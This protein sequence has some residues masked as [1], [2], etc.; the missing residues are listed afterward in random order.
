[1]SS[2]IFPN[3]PFPTGTSVSAYD[4]QGYSTFPAGGPPG[5]PVA[6]ATV[7]A[8]SLTL[9]GLT[10]HHDYFAAAK[11]SGQ[12]KAVRFSVGDNGPP[13]RVTDI[14]Y[15]NVAPGAA[16]VVNADESGFVFAG[17]GV[18]LSVSFFGGAV[19]DGLTDDTV[20]IQA[21]IDAVEAAGGGFVWIPAGYWVFSKLTVPKGVTLA[22][23]GWNCGGIQVPFGGAIWEEFDRLAGSVLISTATSGSAIST[24]SPGSSKVDLR[25]LLVVGPGSGTSSGIQLGTS[26]ASGK[27]V[28]GAYVSNVMA[29]NFATC[30]DFR[31]FEDSTVIGA[32]ARSCHTGLKFTDA[33]NQNELLNTEVQFSDTD[34]MTFEESFLN[35]LRGVLLQNIEGTSGARVISGGANKLQSVW[36]EAAD[37]S[38]SE[39]GGVDRVFDLVAG[40]GTTIEDV[41]QGDLE[42]DQ[43]IRVAS[44][45]ATLRNFGFVGE[46]EILIAAGAVGTKLDSVNLKLVK[47]E[48]TGTKTVPAPTLSGRRPAT[49][50]LTLG[51]TAKLIPGCKE[52]LTLD[53]VAGVIEV[54]GDFDYNAI[55]EED[56]VFGCLFVDNVEQAN[57]ALWNP[58]KVANTR[59]VVSQT[60]RFSLTA[61]VSH[62]FELRAFNSGGGAGKADGDGS[63]M[64]WKQVA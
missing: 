57:H 63:A 7:T 9:T 62:T 46:P 22:G 12:W 40:T 35:T 23:I 49:E 41:Y 55:P 3:T 36:V 34:S 4:A 47:D 13:P 61:G 64:T 59:N 38:V 2:F 16:L 29:A 48:G 60:W 33:T 53:G 6:T 18:G 56:L 51:E 8:G 20:A 30:W 39:G 19:G 52:T 50:A 42:L 54:T 21:T 27:G 32:R 37:G 26:V 17:A 31:W 10:N 58:G 15:A 45:A 14:D 11:V 43:L 25:D 5:S 28:V 44:P 24:S 1:M